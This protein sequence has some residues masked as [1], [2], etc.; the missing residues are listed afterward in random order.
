MHEGPG[1]SGPAGAPLQPH[2]L[3]SIL[4]ESGPLGTSGPQGDEYC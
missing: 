1:A 2:Q 3:S 4:G